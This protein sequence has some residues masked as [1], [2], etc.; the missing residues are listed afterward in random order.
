[1]APD[2]FSRAYASGS[3]KTWDNAMTTPECETIA[4]TCLN[5]A[6]P[7]IAA[8]NTAKAMPATMSAASGSA[9]SWPAAPKYFARL[10]LCSRRS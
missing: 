3:P 5:V 6:S 10:A 4:K 9:I 8:L 7:P 2:R 1:M